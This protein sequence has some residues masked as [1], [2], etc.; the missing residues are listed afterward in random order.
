[1]TFKTIVF[2]FVFSMSLGSAPAWTA[3]TQV[4]LGSYA[5][6][7]DGRPVT[8]ERF[9][10]RLMELRASKDIQLALQTLSPEGKANILDEIIDQKLLA[11]DAHIRKLD[12]DPRIREAVE[13]AVEQV[14]ANAV[15]QMEISALDL[16]DPAL[17]KY[18]RDHAD[19]FRLPDRIKARHIITGTRKDAETALS[20]LQDGRNFAQIAS[21]VNIDATKP[22]GGDLGFVPRGIMVKPFEDALFSLREGETSAIVQTSF[23]YHI[24]RAEK[25]QRGQMQS[26]ESVKETIKS[27]MINECIEQL[28][29]ELRQK[30]AVRINRELLEQ[31]DR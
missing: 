26:F 12:E 8:A 21:D 27:Q 30:Y 16:S 18:Y 3:E 11:I 23:G 31:P 5:A 14:L 1:M 17:Q 15:I 20:E 7:V 9:Q 2:L 22:S 6:I 29:S 4:D 24:I 13:D 19:E 28:K 10:Q 25:I